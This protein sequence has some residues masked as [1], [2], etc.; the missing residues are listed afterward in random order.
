MGRESLE[1][2]LRPIWLRKRMLA[3]FQ[4]SC[5]KQSLD[6][7]TEVD[8]RSSRICSSAKRLRTQPRAPALFTMFSKGCTPSFA[9]T[10]FSSLAYLGGKPYYDVKGGGRVDASGGTQG[11]VPVSVMLHDKQPVL[12]ILFVDGMPRGRGRT[13]RGGVTWDFKKNVL[14]LQLNRNLI[15]SNPESEG[16]RGLV[17]SRAPGCDGATGCMQGQGRSNRR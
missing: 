17:R 1:L 5:T 9:P 6:E 10:R 7:I 4:E 11:T 3:L 13:R 12:G 2:G 14:H 15:V 8:C 16:P